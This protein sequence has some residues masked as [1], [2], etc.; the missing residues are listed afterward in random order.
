M[1]PLACGSVDRTA[2][3]FKR[4]GKGSGGFAAAAFPLTPHDGIV[5]ST[6]PQASGDIP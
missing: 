5:L 1:S 3:F 4:E 6:E 2:A